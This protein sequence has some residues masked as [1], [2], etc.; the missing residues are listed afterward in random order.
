MMHLMVWQ[1]LI[2]GLNFKCH[3]CE[4]CQAIWGMTGQ[5]SS[6]VGIDQYCYRI[7][8]MASPP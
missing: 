8:I 4:H 5:S 3:T 7:I 1:V 2:V 6:A